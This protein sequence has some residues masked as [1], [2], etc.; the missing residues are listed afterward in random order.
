MTYDRDLSDDKLVMLGQQRQVFYLSDSSDKYI[1]TSAHPGM[2]DYVR[3]LSRLIDDI[4]A[5]Q[6]KNISS[7]R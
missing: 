7:F 2:K 4:A 3:Q 1:Q 6:G 5:E